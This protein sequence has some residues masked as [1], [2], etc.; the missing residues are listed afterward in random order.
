MTDAA[1]ST[2][3][4]GMIDSQ[5]RPHR[6]RFKPGPG[7]ERFTKKNPGVCRHCG[8]RR[9]YGRTIPGNARS[10]RVGSLPSAFSRPAE[11]ADALR[12]PMAP[13]ERGQ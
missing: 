11:W 5:L 12:C 10:F 1:W 9:V 6:W 13:E 4:A 2:I 7:W 3:A 8:Q